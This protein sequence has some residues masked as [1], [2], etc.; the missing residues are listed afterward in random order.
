MVT[1]SYQRNH[2]GHFGGQDYLHGVGQRD[3]DSQRET[4]R[5]GY[6]QHRHTDDEEL[7]QEL[8][9]DGHTFL[10]PD[11]ALDPERVNEKASDEDED[12]QS[13]HEQAWRKKNEEKAIY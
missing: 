4:F 5:H 1:Q 3:G 2:W 11:N 7:D 6:H 10:G 9:V 13:W 12:S 8:P